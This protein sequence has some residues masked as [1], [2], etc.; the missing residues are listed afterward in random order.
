MKIYRYYYYGTTLH[1]E[2]IEVIE[3]PKSYVKKG[4]YSERRFLKADVGRVDHSGSLLL[5]LTDDDKK[6]ASLFAEKRKSELEKV[7][8]RKEHLQAEIRYLEGVSN[9]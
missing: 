5:L 6:A 4:R 7:E 2:E 1:K 9:E 3:K 8:K